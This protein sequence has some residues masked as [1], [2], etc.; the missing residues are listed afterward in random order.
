MVG[1]FWPLPAGLTSCPIPPQA[2]LG[3]ASS[4]GKVGSGGVG[5]GSHW[6]EE[7]RNIRRQKKGAEFGSPGRGACLPRPLTLLGPLSSL[8]EMS[9]NLS[10]A[11]GEGLRAGGLETHRTLSC[12]LPATLPSC[13]RSYKKLSPSTIGDITQRQKEPDSARCQESYGPHP[14]LRTGALGKG[15]WVCSPIPGGMG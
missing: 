1:G 7:Q 15:L 9:K 8:L 10:V 5:E 12:C 6:M 4:L 11:A 3:G 14:S 2:L 13:R